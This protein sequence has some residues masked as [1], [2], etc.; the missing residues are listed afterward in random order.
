MKRGSD[1][2]FLKRATKAKASPARK[3]KA[4][5]ARKRN[6]PKDATATELA[7]T[8]ELYGAKASLLS[9]GGYDLHMRP[10][11]GGTYLGRFE[12]REKAI[13]FLRT[14]EVPKRPTARKR[15]RKNPPGGLELML[16]G[17]PPPVAEAILGELHEL[18]YRHAETG[19]DHVHDFGAGASIYCMS[20]G[21]IWIRHPR[22]RLWKEF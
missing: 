15:A 11:H 7:N 17:N 20:D 5:P 14:L 21:S 8:A 22:R 13:R 18:R 16:L 19:V 10:E 4:T 2:R 6:P 12:N 9:V 3:R 1:G